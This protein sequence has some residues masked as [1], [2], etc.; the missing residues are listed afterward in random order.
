MSLTPYVHGTQP[1][2]PESDPWE[3]LRGESPQAYEALSHY[4]DMPPAT[5]TCRAVAEAIGKSRQIVLRW[6]SKWDWVDRAADWDAEQ[7]KAER[8]H[9]LAEIERVNRED[10]DMAEQGLALLLRYMP[11]AAALGNS[12]HAWAEWA[13]TLTKIKRDALGI[14][15][16]D[17]RMVVAGD[18]S[19]PIQVHDDELSDAMAHLPPAMV[20]QLRDISL[21]MTRLK[22]QRRLGILPTVP[23]PTVVS[24]DEVTDAE[25]VGPQG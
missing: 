19:S 13:K 20:I 25:V 2:E 10:V 18:P 8:R 15:E 23:P 4:L 12:P 22:S 17:C 1:T 9:R 7:V 14:A 3:R 21:E 5:R 6:S 16:P 24:D 11:T